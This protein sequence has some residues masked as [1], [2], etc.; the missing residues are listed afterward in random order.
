MAYYTWKG[1]DLA[2]AIKKGKLFA[3]SADELDAVL[4]KQKI[5]LLSCK[6]S[7]QFFSHFSIPKTEKINFF[8][9]LAQLLQA[10]VL[11][12]DA[13]IVVSSQ[14]HHK[15]WHIVLSSISNSI[16]QGSSLSQALQD[17][18]KIFDQVMINMV[19]VGQESGNL[20]ESL[21]LLSDYLSDSYEFES[22]VRSAAMVPLITLIFFIIVAMAIFI[23]IIPHFITIFQSVNQELPW[24][25]RIMIGMSDFFCSGHIFL[26]LGCIGAA[27]A[28]L[29]SYRSS[30]SGSYA[31]DS[32]L[33]QIPGLGYLIMQRSLAHFLQAM[34][35]LTS[36]GMHIVDALAVSKGIVSN[37]LIVHHLSIIEKEVQAGVSLSQAMMY[38]QGQIFGAQ[39]VAIIKVGQESGRLPVLLNQTAKMYQSSI[40]KTITLI[41]TLINPLLMIVMGLLITFLVFAV[42]LPIFNLSNVI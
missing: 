3:R 33:L 24:V 8:K 18:P 32:F 6:Q 15:Q 40:K 36:G 28:L 34:A 20:I 17:Y 10:G 9:S 39:T 27:L 13:L 2:G 23:F 30:S 26:F 31:L 25:T 1:V 11:L 12:P 42:Y 21:T 7:S 22:N 16:F 5:A 35:M 4:F 37:K 29:K 14:A 41:T 19:H 38:E